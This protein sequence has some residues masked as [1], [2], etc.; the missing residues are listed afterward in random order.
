MR[1]EPETEGAS[2]GRLDAEDGSS[3]RCWSAARERAGV[4]AETNNSRRAVGVAGSPRIGIE[5]SRSGS[6]RVW[7]SLAVDR[8]HTTGIALAQT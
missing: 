3:L 8:V 2:D 7:S 1:G 4:G 6:S 5:L